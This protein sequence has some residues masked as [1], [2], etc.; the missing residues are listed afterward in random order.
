MIS[1]STRSGLREVI[2][3]LDCSTRRVPVHVNRGERV[4]K[5]WAYGDEMLA[6]SASVA[7][8]PITDHQYTGGTAP[9]QFVAALKAFLLGVKVEPG[10]GFLEDINQADRDCEV[11]SLKRTR[12][13]IEY[14][15]PNAGMV[16]AWRKPGLARGGDW[17]YVPRRYGDTCR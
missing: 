11:L 6:F 15:M 1:V 14:E 10:K 5:I 17:Y 3:A 13:R 9:D 2:Q 8:D 16:Q 7:G 12:F 4:A